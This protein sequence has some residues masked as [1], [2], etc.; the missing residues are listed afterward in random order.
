MATTYL[1]V[2]CEILL[3]KLRAYSITGK[4]IYFNQKKKNLSTQTNAQVKRNQN[5]NDPFQTTS[6]VRQGDSMSPPLL[7]HIP[8]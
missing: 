3:N 6:G 7:Q 8:R 4:N 2:N 1:W 5:F